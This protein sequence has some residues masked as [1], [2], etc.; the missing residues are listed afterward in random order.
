MSFRLPLIVTVVGVALAVALALTSSTPMKGDLVPII[1]SAFGSALIVGLSGSAMLRLLRPQRTQL[2]TVVVALVA[3]AGTAVGIAVTSRGM[4]INEH[5]LDV[6]MVVL[7]SSA[8]VGV[9][10]ALA[11]GNQVGRSSRLVEDLARRIGEG[12]AGAALE[13]R[14]ATREL[15]SIASEL[16]AMSTRLDEAR[17]RERE[18][19]A[20]RRELV[21]WVSHDL[22]TPLA[23]IRAMVEALEDRV[24]DDP[25]TVDRYYATMREETDR[26]SQLVDD[27]FE[28]SRIEAGALRL[29]RVPVAI[30][31]LISDAVAA[32][33]PGASGEGVALVAELDGVIPVV[34]VGIREM[35]RALQNV[36]DNA[37]RHS[38]E[39]GIVTV[40][41]DTEGQLVVVRVVDAG[42]GIDPTIIDRVFELGFT[43]DIAR[44]PGG[45]G[46]SGL[47]LA[48]AQGFVRAHGGEI[49]VDNVVNADG[50][51]G[52]RFSIGLP[53]FDAGHERQADLVR[54]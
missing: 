12:E 43:G 28:L 3:V 40:T 53:I 26:L 17:R 7:V 11:L 52:A 4:F 13:K 25:E 50:L 48:I 32:V 16:T 20:A 30:G 38:P 22:R 15:A 37:V 39:G 51:K 47:G 44:S 2:Q 54:S 27:L 19:E 49:S 35:S 6:L 29:D 46:G 9:L 10:A 33:T 8:T 41:V 42:G 34:A 1:A 5:D 14:P 23:G 21:A 24:V 18:L 36:L 45:R 31:E